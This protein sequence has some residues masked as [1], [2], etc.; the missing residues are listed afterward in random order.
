MNFVV[1][2]ANYTSGCQGMVFPGKLGR[3]N[4]KFEQEMASAST[5]VK[6]RGKESRGKVKKRPVAQQIHEKSE[7]KEVRQNVATK[8]NDG[9]N[10]NASNEEKVNEM[11]ATR[12][13]PGSGHIICLS[14]VILFAAA[15]L[16]SYRT[17]DSNLEKVFGDGVDELQLSFTN[18][19]ERFWKILKNRGLAHLRNNNPSQPLVFLLAAPPPAHEWV[20][21][22]ATKLAEKLDPRHEGDLASIDGIDE[23]GYPGDEIKKKMDVYLKKEFLDGHK[24]AVIH[25]LE[26]LPPSSTLLFYS[27]CDDQNAP[28]KDV[29]IIFTVHLPEEPSLS[30]SPKEAEAT[31]EKYLSKQVWFRE[32]MDAVAALL[33]R[34]SNTVALMNGESSDSLKA[35][36]S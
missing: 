36:C 8:K 22:L 7:G 29:A 17:S 23:K 13:K 14:V 18:Q 33:S 32:D 35:F 31:V 1:R 28:Y 12:W 30:L 16:W 2:T 9:Q 15:L 4:T 26:L 19:T 21:C 25:H 24:V 3:M 6:G 10:E 20:D 5:E 34:V 27:Y 11:E